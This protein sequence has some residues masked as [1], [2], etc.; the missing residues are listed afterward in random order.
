MSDAEHKLQDVHADVGAGTGPAPA[1][2]VNQSAP[3]PAHDDTPGVG[4]AEA[5][6]LFPP[7]NLSRPELLWV[8]I[9]F[10]FKL[11]LDGLRD[12]LLSPVSIVTTILGVLEGGKDPGRYLRQTIDLGRRSERWINLFGRYEEN[13]AD[14]L[15]KP[16]E[17]RFYDEI[18][19]T[20]AA[21]RSAAAERVRD[22]KADPAP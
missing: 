13:T 2:R 15:M 17:Q 11:V 5:P 9:V 4:A 21:K 18:D 22:D 7:K 1:S 6:P 19:P 16:L 14:E 3:S 8:L 10:Q 20:G 12:V